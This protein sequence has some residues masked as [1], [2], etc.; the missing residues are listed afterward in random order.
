MP[1][2]TCELDTVPD[3]A[4]VGMAENVFDAPLIVLLVKVSEPVLVATVESIAKVTLFPDA[5]ASIPVPPKR[6]NV[7]DMKSI[8]IVELPSVISRFC[9]VT[10]E[11]T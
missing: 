9:A 6:P 8:E 4:E 11:F 1:V 2:P 10:C 7:S 5:V 3:S